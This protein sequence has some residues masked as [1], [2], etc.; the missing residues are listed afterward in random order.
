MTRKIFGIVI[1]LFIALYTFGIKD[2]FAVTKRILNHVKALSLPFNVVL[3]LFCIFAGCFFDF[4]RAVLM[5]I[6]DEYCIFCSDFVRIGKKGSI[7]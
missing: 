7:H 5:I 1:Q 3:V 2:V 4:S 6:K